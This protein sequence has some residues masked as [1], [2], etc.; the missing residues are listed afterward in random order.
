MKKVTLLILLLTLSLTLSVVLVTA[1]ELVITPSPISLSVKQDEAKDFNAT[2]KNTFDFEIR[3]FQFSNLTGFTFE[4]I[5][6]P[7]G[8]EKVIE[9]SVKSSSLG[10]HS[11]SPTVSFRYLVD[12]PVQPETHII[13]VTNTGYKPTFLELHEGDT[14]TWKNTDDITHTI[15]STLW[16]HELSPNETISETFNEVSTITYQDTVQFFGGTLEILDKDQE[17]LVHN[18]ENDIVWGINLEVASDPTSIKLELIDQNF[19]IQATGNTEGLLSIENTG[20]EIAQNIKLKT[21]NTWITFEE[22]NFN[23]EIGEK[24]IVTYKINPA[25]FDSNETNKTYNVEVTAKAI[26]TEEQKK[27]VS[28]FIPYND[29]V[30]GFGSNE[31]FLI[32]FDKVF[33]AG[34]KDLFICNTSVAP[35][36]GQIIIR[37]PELDVNLTQSEFI[38]T[39]RRLRRIE[40][41][42]GRSVNTENQLANFLQSELPGIKNSQNITSQ[43]LQELEERNR[44]N[45]A[46]FW[47]VFF[48]T[49]IGGTVFLGLRYYKEQ[50]RKEYRMEGR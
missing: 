46:I 10:S 28:I 44:S 4:E 47:S 15:T 49:I 21:N 45:S 35:N 41:D 18:P 22:N 26:N 37:D 24:N 11:F 31:D 50:K 33:C 6:I 1:Q 9:F 25:I 5:I 29:I 43:V 38:D 23:L 39:L 42:L 14:V 40:D 27:V 16:D 36:N 17:N 34:N 7:S 13:E 12:I 3:S 2:F 30:S 19:S 48:L 20:T 32:W 8:E